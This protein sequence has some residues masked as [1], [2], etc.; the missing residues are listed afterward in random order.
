VAL[1]LPV[2]W[3][4]AAALAL[5]LASF[6]RL[7]FAIAAT[8]DRP[9]RLAARRKLVAARH[10]FARELRSQTPRMRDDWY[11]YLIAFGL[12]GEIDRWFRAFVTPAMATTFHTWNGPMAGSDSS[13]PSWTGGGGAF[14]GAGASGSW[15]DAA[16][17]LG[18]GVPAPGSSGG[19]GGGGGSSSGGGGG[20]GW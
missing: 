17:T 15:A 18:S 1:W 11:P 19:G 2:T 5:L 12:A 13:G 8:P 3:L 16:T 14:G 4:T 20:G 6:W 7:A 10:F 9:E